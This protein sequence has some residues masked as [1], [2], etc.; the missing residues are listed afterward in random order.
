MYS[1]AVA[2]KLFQIFLILNLTL[3]VN[4]Q[5]FRMYNSMTAVYHTGQL[6]YRLDLKPWDR[7]YFFLYKNLTAESNNDDMRSKKK[8]SYGTATCIT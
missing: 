4:L 7:K 3:V 6:A 8:Y 2:I 1:L 5:G